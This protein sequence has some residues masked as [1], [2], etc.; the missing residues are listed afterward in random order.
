MLTEKPDLIIRIGK[1]WLIG[2]IGLGSTVKCGQTLIGIVMDA[3]DDGDER[4][5]KI[6]FDK[7]F[8][9]SRPA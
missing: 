9:I 7:D 8:Q 6:K 1:E 5:V 4:V 2:Y 3:E